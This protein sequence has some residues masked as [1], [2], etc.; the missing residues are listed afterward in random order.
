MNLKDGKGRR[1]RHGLKASRATLGIVRA[2]DV[3]V[4][5]AVPVAVAG[6]WLAE[7]ARAHA[8]EFLEPVPLENRILVRDLRDLRGPPLRGTSQC[9]GG[10]Y[11]VA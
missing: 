5:R 2:R 8:D 9:S 1:E 6:L 11:S 4:P 7:L 10:R 3:F